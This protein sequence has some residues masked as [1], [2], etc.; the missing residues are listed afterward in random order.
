[1]EK[2]GA[3]SKQIPNRNRISEL[4][5]LAPDAPLP[6]PPRPRKQVHRR[7]SPEE[8]E[9]LA[10]GYRAGVAVNDLAVAFGINRN[11]VLEQVGRMNLPRRYPALSAEEVQ[12]AAELYE[13]GQSLAMI[14]RILRVH[15]T[16]VRRQLIK[17]G[18]AIRARAGWIC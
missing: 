11:T 6:A 7:L 1:M 14:G 16:T 12:Q 15:A 5:E 8:R 17:A 9:L 10:S 13:S 18:V 2:L 4:G 3:Y